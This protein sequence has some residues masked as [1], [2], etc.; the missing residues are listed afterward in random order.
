MTRRI[1][2]TVCQLAAIATLVF[3]F[4]YFLDSRFRVLP[5]SIHKHLLT[6]YPG[7]VITDITVSYCSGIYLLTSCNL[8]PKRWH[9]VEK[10]LYLGS[11][12]I[13]SAYVYIER[14]KEEDLLP[15]DRVVFDVTVG[16]LNPNAGVQVEEDAI[17]ESRPM[18][19]WL[20][21]S[22]KRHASDSNQAVTAVEV[23]FGADAVDPRIGWHLVGTAMLLNTKGE[24][25][26]A[27]LSVRKGKETE[28]PKP[29]PKINEHGKFKIMQAA[30]LHL[31]TGTGK[32][33]D[34]Q[35]PETAQNC[36]ADPRT[37][38]FME[39][40]LDT[41]KP[42]LVILS[43]DQVNGETAPDTQ[44]AIFKYAYILVERKIPFASIFGNHDDEGSLSRNIQMDIIESLPYS[45]ASAGPT[46]IDGVGNYYVEVH[47][48]G[49]KH[50]AI[51]I[52]LLDSHAYS[53]DER[54]FKGYDWLKKNQ[55]D[56]FKATSTELK[57]SH[58][59][60]S[61]I[62]MD[63]AFIHIPIPEF[64]DKSLPRQG[65]W[66]E[67]VTAPVFNSGFRDALVE[68]GVLLLGCGHD[69]AN[70]YCALSSNEQLNPALWMCYAGGAGFGGYGGYGG[71][72]RRI[73]FYEV[74]VNEARITTWKRVEGGVEAN[75]KVDE[76]VIVDG[77]RMKGMSQ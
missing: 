61:H 64:R 65:E 15:E 76:Q 13:R 6:H 44:S 67:S 32:C 7:L 72:Q 20:K 59:G 27:R 42:D 45:L 38:E 73:R 68:Q 46:T 49:S 47:A 14:K 31:S 60:Y 74:D 19:L 16:R 22:A 48:H 28:V 57:R 26:E 24:K 63:L 70:E 56:W 21:R 4:V 43:G 52:Y 40:L 62:H 3:I 69:H 37:I 2:R 11:G 50:S 34:P 36:E 23:L 5:T 8:H 75:G 71:Y 77:G 1:V 30:D 10:D 66:R 58:E 53:P 41:E 25:F 35:P 9:R 54:N 33:R 39:K 17:W 55:I 29:I 51:T 12:W 18:G